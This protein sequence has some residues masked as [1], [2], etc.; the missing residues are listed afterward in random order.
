[1]NYLTC[2]LAVRA[3]ILGVVFM[4]GQAVSQSSVSNPTAELD[5]FIKEAEDNSPAILEARWKVEQAI[6]R[7]RE[8]LEFLDP[9]FMAAVGHADNSKSIPGSTNYSSTANNASELQVGVE[10]PFEQGFYLAIG[11]AERLLHDQ[12]GYSHLAQTLV[13]AR[14]RIPLLRDR[15]FATLAHDRA[16][17]KAEYNAAVSNLLKQMQIIRRD[18]TLAYVAVY[19]SQMSY[20]VTI[21]AS[22]RFRKL[23]DEATELERLGVIPGYQ[24]HDA[25]MDYQIGL[26]NEEIARNKVELNMIALS[27]VLGRHREIKLL[28]ENDEEYLVN[29]ATEAQPPTSVNLERS[30]EAR[31]SYLAIENTIEQARVRILSAEEE[32]KDDLSLNFGVAWQAES[33]TQ[34]LGT[35][36]LTGVERPGAEIA[37]VWKRRLDYRGPQARVARFTAQIE[38][39]KQ[40]LRAETVTIESEIRNALNNLATARRRLEIVNKGIEASEKTLEAEQERFKLGQ[41]TSSVVTDAQKDLTSLKQRRT[42]AAADLLRAWANLQYATGYTA[43]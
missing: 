1:M 3:I 43:K 20:R 12:A 34:A 4:V 25:R 19:E 7:H 38:Q 17:A 6:I 30:C 41:A 24:I 11:G 27:A 29:A 39:Y 35:E 37:L 5:A 2:R 31:G 21:E 36:E 32:M 14:V 10:I 8:L 23:V 26:E 42:S 22:E 18:V 9:S 15:G 33:D 16:L 13:G 28:H 40:Q